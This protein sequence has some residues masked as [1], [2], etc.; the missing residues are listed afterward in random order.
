MNLKS[1]TDTQLINDTTTAVTAERRITA[2]TIKYFFEVNRRKLHLKMGYESLFTMLRKHWGYCEP[3]AHL[4][5]SAVS[6]MQDVPEVIE[7]IESG[8]MPVTV[9]ANI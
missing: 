5:K 3:T 1:L 8:E 2:E 6:L 7:K 9:A 4:R